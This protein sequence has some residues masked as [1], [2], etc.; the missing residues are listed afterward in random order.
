MSNDINDRSVWPD[1]EDNPI[2]QMLARGDEWY[3]NLEVISALGLNEGRALISS[4]APA[5]QRSL[6]EG[7]TMATVRGMML[8]VAQENRS[9]S[10]RGNAHF[11]NRRAVILAAMRTNTVN[12]AAF[13]DWMATEMAEL[14]IVPRLRLGAD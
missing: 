14:A 2:V 7:D 3:S 8:P 6:A 11:F 1:P 4:L 5:F 13:R 10:G 12:G 9:H